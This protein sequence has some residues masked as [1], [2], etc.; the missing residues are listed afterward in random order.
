MDILYKPYER[1]M[2]LNLRNSSWKVHPLD[3]KML[4]FNRQTGIN[5]LIEGDETKLFRRIAPRT[6]QIALTNFCNLTC[7]FCYR[8]KSSNSLWR[9]DT[10]L[11]FCQAADA[12]GLLEIAFGGGEP[13][14]FPRFQDLLCE[15]Y[16][17]THLCVNFTT[18]G[19][20]L[21]ESFLCAVSGKYGQIRLSI[22]EDNKWQETIKLFVKC[23]GR[24][25]V[26]WLIT[27]NELKTFEDKF[28]HLFRLGVRDFLFLSYKGNDSGLHLSHEDYPKF[29][30]IIQKIY[31][32]YGDKVAMKFDV[33]WGNTLSNI[34]RLFSSNDCGA[35]DDL[36]SIT[37]DFKIQ[38]CSFHN[39]AFPFHTIDDVRNYW[40]NKR[41]ARQAALIAGCARLPYRGLNA[42]GEPQYEDINLARV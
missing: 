19:T 36:L 5:I 22:Y 9:C 7:S 32:S 18:N 20:L 10:I 21:S 37:S 3:G 23:E 25:G 17:T 42:Q 35:G 26:N 12:W 38:P 15:L 29:E 27:P 1:Y 16:D 24:F 41:N 30:H 40:E 13:M 33:C 34:P 28:R 2:P 4:L 31:E 8:E 14:I 6:L 39:I 11:D